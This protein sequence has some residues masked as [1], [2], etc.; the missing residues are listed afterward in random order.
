MYKECLSFD[1]LYFFLQVLC[2][3]ILTDRVITQKLGNSHEKRLSFFRIYF[4]AMLIA[5]YLTCRITRFQDRGVI[6]RRNPAIISG[7]LTYCVL[8]GGAQS[9]EK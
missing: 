3:I 9:T 8:V 1:I 2:S 5:L 7:H 4:S 6:K